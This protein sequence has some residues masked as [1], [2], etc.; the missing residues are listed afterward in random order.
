MD[1][2]NILTGVKT[3]KE[4]NELINLIEKLIENNFKKSFAPND[5]ILN[6]GT[7]RKLWEGVSA[8]LIAG[9]ISEDQKEREKFLD[10]LLSKVRSQNKLKVTIAIEPNNKLLERLRDWTGKNL[11][12]NT[13]LDITVDPQILGGAIIVSSNGEYADFSLFKRINDLFLTRK[14]EILSL[15]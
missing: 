10:S 2:A 13:I 9:N 8:A 3:T 1:Q 12:G 15:L 5:E 4:Q 11:S 14:Q 7:T 6:S